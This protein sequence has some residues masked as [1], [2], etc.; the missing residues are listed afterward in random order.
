MDTSS[1]QQALI[2][3][4]Q[5]EFDNLTL[6]LNEN[7][8]KM[9]MKVWSDKKQTYRTTPMTAPTKSLAEILQLVPLEDAEQIS[10]FQGLVYMPMQFLEK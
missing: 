7:G 5:R 8:W 2:E 10:E 9:R 4:N 1:T 3:Q 6:M